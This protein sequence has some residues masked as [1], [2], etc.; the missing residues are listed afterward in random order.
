MLVEAVESVLKQTLPPDEIIV[1]DNGSTDETITLSFDSRVQ[2]LTES[3]LGA[4][5]A[6]SKGLEKSRSRFILFLDSDDILE[7]NGLEI[8][9]REISS[10]EAL[11]CFGAMNNF[12]SAPGESVPEKRVHYPIA[13]NTLIARASFEQVGPFDGDNYSFPKWIF[14]ARRLGV[15][16][17]HVTDV[18][19]KRRIHQDN[20][21]RSE[22]SKQFYINLVRSRLENK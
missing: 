19:S 20:L 21:S 16:E 17:T 10:K 14:E 7:Q 11:F 1:V 3:R 22:E 9:H 8:L 5:Y 4:G 12:G 2:L 18:V 6:R 13:S 15:A